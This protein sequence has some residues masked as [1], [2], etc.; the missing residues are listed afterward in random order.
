MHH[1]SQNWKWHC[2]CA[3]SL[4][5]NG[6]PA[7]WVMAVS[8]F[9]QAYIQC[10]SHPLPFVWSLGKLF[11]LPVCNLG[12]VFLKT[13]HH[14][15]LVVS[16]IQK[17]KF[18]D[19]S[20]LNSVMLLPNGQQWNSNLLWNFDSSWWYTQQ[21]GRWRT[22]AQVSGRRPTHPTH[23]KFSRVWLLKLFWLKMLLN[24]GPLIHY[25]WYSTQNMK[26]QF[27]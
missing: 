2:K 19:V 13:N 6:N 10:T 11:C 15:L 8:F 7:F 21:R 25:I 17:D 24:P 20:I 5:G 27:F 14:R 23:E 3:P 1:S 16:H 26:T 12:E 4:L 9:I 18:M 22:M